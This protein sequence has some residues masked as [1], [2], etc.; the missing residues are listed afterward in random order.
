MGLILLSGSESLA[1][2]SLSHGSHFLTEHLFSIKKI[3]LVYLDALCDC[4]TE[5]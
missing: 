1:R 5:F 3:K 2:E 4:E